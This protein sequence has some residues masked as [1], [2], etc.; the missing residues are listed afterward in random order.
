MDY[1][2]LRFIWWALVGILLIGFSIMDG[3]DMGVGT[4]SVFVGKTDLERRAAINS[5]A[6]HWDG[7]QVWF[8]TAGGAVFAAWPLV[9]AASFSMLYIAILAVLWTIF[10]RAP[11]FEY[12]GKIENNSWRKTWDWI[13]FI[14]STVPPILF[15]VAFGNLFLGI[16]FHYDESMRLFNDA[17]SPLVGFLSLL[18]PFAILCG[19]VSLCMITAH[20]GIYLTL[21]TEGDMQERARKLAAIFSTL[22]II[23]F[24]FGGVYIAHINGYTALNLDPNG[25][26]NPF[27]KTVTL[28]PGGWLSNYKNYP[29]LTLIPILAFTGLFLSIV[30]NLA[31]KKSGLAFILSGIGIAGII[32]TAGV[33]L[34]P[35]ILPSSTNLSSSLTVWDATSSKYTLQAMLIAALIF[36]PIILTYTSWVYNIMRGK[37]TV[38]KIKENSKAYY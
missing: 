6:P 36:T 10:L 12:R 15:G 21:R 25:A 38:A 14:G 27:F 22:T 7:N 9:Y 16:P 33:S 28:I 20:G 37:L 29:I 5:V 4:L 8:I 1:A 32:L 23:F 34:F 35:F 19:L 30:S 24:A 18:H 11:A 31:L 13:L 17:T 3:H 2:I 26:S